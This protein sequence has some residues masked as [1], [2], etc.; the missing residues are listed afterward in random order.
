MK[1][2]VENPFVSNIWP[3][4]TRIIGTMWKRVSSPAKLLRIVDVHHRR[5][6]DT[7]VFDDKTWAY[8]TSMRDGSKMIFVAN[9]PSNKK[10]TSSSAIYSLRQEVARLKNEV[11]A[12]KDEIE[13][14]KQENDNLEHQMDEI[15][16]RARAVIRY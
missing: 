2:M 3:E 16:E 4:K 5:G 6:H 14:L 13:D 1:N 11:L 9:A 12:L 7:V 10:K 8:V 15:E